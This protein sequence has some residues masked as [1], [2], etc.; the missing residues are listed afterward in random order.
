MNIV[1]GSRFSRPPTA[2]GIRSVP[3]LTRQ[4]SIRARMV[5]QQRRRIEDERRLRDL[6]VF[7][8]LRHR[9]L[10][11]VGPEE[12]AAAQILHVGP[13]ID[14]GK[15]AREMNRPQRLLVTN[16]DD[17]ACRQN[18]RDGLGSRLREKLLDIGRLPAARC[19]KSSAVIRP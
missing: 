17:L 18:D 2:L 8:R 14:V 10:R 12:D 16:E 6:R 11:R 19:S 13:E 1:A 5:A 3:E 4:S 7:P 9:R 15:T